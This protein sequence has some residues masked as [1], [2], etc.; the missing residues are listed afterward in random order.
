VAEC[1]FYVVADSRF[2]LG[3]VALINSL[4][5]VGHD[6]PIFVVDNGLDHAQ[7][8]LL[9]REATLLPAPETDHPV[10]LRWVAPRE[11]PAEVMILVDADV[12]VVRSLAPLVQL[13][14]AGKLAAFVDLAPDRFDEGWAGFLGVAT[15]PRRPYL[16]GG[17]L[18]LPR[19]RGLDLLGLLDRIQAELPLELVRSDGTRPFV[20][21]EQDVL[22]A[23]LAAHWPE[24]DVVVLERRLAPAPPF[25]ALS[26]VDARTL[27]CRFR[28]G[29][30]PY[31]LHHINEKPWLTLTD[32]TPYSQLLPRLLLA[33]DLAIRLAPA[34]VSF[35]LRPGLL[36]G[37]LRALLTLRWLATKSRF[38]LRL[39]L[40]LSRRDRG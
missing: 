25:H 24:E 18:A 12:I 38:K 9:A 7:R 15:L 14:A 3:V 8:A 37:A 16:N 29:A 13:A 27:E 28:D 33:D 4:R 20:F 26:V 11:R 39:L 32:P 6:D 23:V 21:R 22:N 10:Y 2:F 36:P 34:D 17:F 40:G 5:L 35:R 31:L 19:A 1:A 30:W